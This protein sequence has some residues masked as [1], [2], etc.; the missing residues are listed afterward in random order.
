MQ[1]NSYITDRALDIIAISRGY[2]QNELVYTFG[3]NVNQT[4]MAA[5]GQGSNY[6]TSVSKN[7]RNWAPIANVSNSPPTRVIWDGFKWIVTRSDTAD[8]LYSYNDAQASTFD[9]SNATLASIAYNSTLY[10][11]IGKGG[12]FFSYDGIHWSNS[13]SG[14]ALI[15]NTSASQIGKVVWNGSLWV[16]VGNG[17]SYTI[18]YSSDGINWTGVANSSTI[19]DSSGGAFDLA[20]NGTLWVATGSNSS[21]NLVAISYN[22]ITWTNLNSASQAFLTAS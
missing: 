5:I 10:V 14:T 7:I 12:V 17:A 13:A 9:V 22:G 2:A 6:G 20:W 15:N 21:G 8:V 3:K 19:F 1:A 16:A 11:G 4:Y 18:I